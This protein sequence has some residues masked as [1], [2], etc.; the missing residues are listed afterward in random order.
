MLLHLIFSFS[1]F[2][3]APGG[4]L[5]YWGNVLREQSAPSVN[6]T[7]DVG[8]GHVIMATPILGDTEVIL[9]TSEGCLFRVHLPSPSQVQHIHIHV[10]CYFPFYMLCLPSTTYVHTLLAIVYISMYM[11]VHVHVYT[12]LSTRHTHVCVC[13]YCTC[14]YTQPLLTGRVLHVTHGLLSGFS[15]K[16][17]SLFFGSS[18]AT[19]G[20]RAEG[21]GVAI[22]EL[23][24]GIR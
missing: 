9:F 12:S 10:H 16:V 14:I 22:R 23:E 7:V 17:S 18:S 5:H 15:R 20:Q 1:L 21:R 11:Y 6:G 2:A 8:T 13:I 19:G 3:A 24:G 4:R